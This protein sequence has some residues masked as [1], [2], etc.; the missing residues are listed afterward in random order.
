MLQRLNGEVLDYKLHLKRI[1]DDIINVLNVGANAFIP[2]LRKN[3]YKFWWDHEHDVF[4]T[5]SVQSNRI[6]KLRASQKMNQFLMDHNR[7][8]CNT[9]KNRKNRQLEL[10]S[11]SNDCTTLYE[12]EDGV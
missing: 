4:K 1:H 5:A 2:R 3:F 7:V 6:C 12:K 11:Y 10:T 9:E 8:D